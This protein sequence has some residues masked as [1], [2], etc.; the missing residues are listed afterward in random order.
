MFNIVSKLD[1]GVLFDN[2]LAR[3]KDLYKYLCKWFLFEPCSQEEVVFSLLKRILKVRLLIVRGI[4]N[5]DGYIEIF[6]YF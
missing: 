1:S 6:I 5:L 4:Y 2:D 3:S